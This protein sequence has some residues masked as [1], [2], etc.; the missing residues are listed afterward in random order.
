[1]NSS[2]ASCS[3][4]HGYTISVNDSAAKHRCDNCLPCDV[5]RLHDS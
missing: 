5:F 3:A 2:T 4:Q 1:L